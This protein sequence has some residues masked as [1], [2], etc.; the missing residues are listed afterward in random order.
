MPKPPDAKRLRCFVSVS[1]AEYEHAILEALRLRDVEAVTTA[2]LVGASTVSNLLAEAIKRADFVIVVV[3]PNDERRSSSDFDLGVAFALRKPL[4]AVV[5]PDWARLSSDLAGVQLIRARPGDREALDFLV[6]QLVEAA[7]HLRK[8]RSPSGGAPAPSSARN[9]PFRAN[10]S[11][12][13]AENELV[14]AFRRAGV[15]AVAEPAVAGGRPDLA[16]WIPELESLGNPILLEL[17]ISPSQESVRRSALQLANY[18]ERSG[19]TLGLVV[20]SDGWQGPRGFSIGSSRVL[21]LSIG[22][23][24][25]AAGSGTVAQ[26]IRERYDALSRESD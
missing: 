1:D 20:H 8:S 13:A 14:D 18:L 21:Y 16:L 4:A 24:L 26:L 9:A 6:R 10:L 2:D 11:P 17:K 7:S 12:R 3:S 25:D 5:N 19:T 23:I 15:V 22:E